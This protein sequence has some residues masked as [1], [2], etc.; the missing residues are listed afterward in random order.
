M[1]KKIK[2]A[3][4]TAVKVEITRSKKLTGMEIN[5]LVDV[6]ITKINDVIDK[7]NKAIWETPEYKAAVKAIKTKHKVL[8][9]DKELVRLKQEFPAVSF[10]VTY[11][12]EFRDEIRTLDNKVRNIQKKSSINNYNGSSEVKKI[13]NRLILE[14][15]DSSLSIFELADKIA[16]EYLSK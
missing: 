13:K 7:H 8:K 3:K 6:T 11:S 9:A 2:E 1:T 10:S 16:Q 4:T 12:Q 15:V 5:A 14:Q